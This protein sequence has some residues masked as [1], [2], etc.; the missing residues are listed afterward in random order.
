MAINKVI[1]I[2]NLEADPVVR[3]LPNSGQ[4]VANFSLATTERFT[5]RKRHGARVHGMAQGS[6]I[7]AA[8]GYVRTVPQ[9]R[10]P[11]VRRRAP[12]HPPYEAKDESA[13]ASGLKLWRD[14]SGFLR[15]GRAVPPQRRLRKKSPLTARRIGEPQ[16][17]LS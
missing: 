9:Q 7:R 11:S 4:N 8:G 16:R 6:G 2:G 3:T 10:P 5:D 13:S 15:S 17:R 12:Y 14:K 1:V